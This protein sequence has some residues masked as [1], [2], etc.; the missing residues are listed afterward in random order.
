MIALAFFLPG[1]NFQI[2]ARLGRTLIEAHLLNL[3]ARN[4]GRL[5]W[6]EFVRQVY[7]G[8]SYM[9]KELQKSEGSPLKSLAE[10]KS[11]QSQGETL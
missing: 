4:L 7:R 3:G 9:Y 5:S 8:E 6:L 2:A 1:G 11:V 10:Y